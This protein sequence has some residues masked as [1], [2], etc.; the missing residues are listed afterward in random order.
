MHGKNG[1]YTDRFLWYHWIILFGFILFLGGM[2]AL[3]TKEAI[4]MLESQPV[5]G[6]ILLLVSLFLIGIILY[7]LIGSIKQSRNVTDWELTD[8]GYVTTKT[9]LETNEIQRSEF[10]FSSA[11]KCLISPLSESIY[12]TN[13]LDT[14][15]RYYKYITLNIVYRKEDGKLDVF[16]FADYREEELY[17]WLLNLQEH[18]VP[19]EITEFELTEVPAIDFLDVVV[20]E[21]D[22]RPYILK[23]SL[24]DLGLKVVTTEKPNL[25]TFAMTKRL[26]QEDLF[27]KKKLGNKVI[28]TGQF[29]I[30]VLLHIFYFFNFLLLW[31]ITI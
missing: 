27:V 1:K 7:M 8:K 23:D 24:K 20:K 31:G 6:S 16:R 29:I 25:Y 2:T 10:R 30:I 21:V 12:Q 19:L 22:W 13:S 11:I 28:F 26:M 17:P 18:N 9:N 15:T 4:E 5:L 3:I 14:K